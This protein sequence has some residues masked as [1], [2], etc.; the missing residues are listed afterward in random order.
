MDVSVLG[1]GGAE[2]GYENAST[3][4]AGTLLNRALDAGINVIDTAGP[5]EVF[6]DVGADG[7]EAN[8]FELYSVAPTK[9]AVRTRN[10][11]LRTLTLTLREK[12]CRM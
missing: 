1:F 2:I 7:G 10:N 6:Q 5:W 11:A 12:I 9:D 4:T 8:P 3:D